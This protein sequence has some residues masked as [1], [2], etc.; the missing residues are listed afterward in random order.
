MIHGMIGSTI[1]LEK[2]DF[3]LTA[4]IAWSRDNPR[5]WESRYQVEMDSLAYFQKP[6]SYR[7]RAAAAE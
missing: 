7:V 6:R 1:D 2:N 5:T 4:T 3:T